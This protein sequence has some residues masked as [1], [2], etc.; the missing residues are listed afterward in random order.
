MICNPLGQIVEIPDTSLS[1]KLVPANDNHEQTALSRE[2]LEA[3]SILTR[4]DG[5][6]LGNGPLLIVAAFF[7]VGACLVGALAG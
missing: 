4:P 5:I 7:L 6:Q 1:E 2:N 3:E